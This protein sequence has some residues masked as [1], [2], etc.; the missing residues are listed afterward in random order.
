MHLPKSLAKLSESFVGDSID[1]EMANGAREEISP[2][3]PVRRG[4]TRRELN[5]V[6]YVSRSNVVFPAKS[7]SRVA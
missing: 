7:S 3:R 6:H 4:L 5:Q 1:D 2:R